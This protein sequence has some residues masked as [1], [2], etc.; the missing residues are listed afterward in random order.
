MS[1]IDP[2]RVGSLPTNRY[3]LEIDVP[4]EATARRPIMSVDYLLNQNARTGLDH[5]RR[6]R[7][8][9]YVL[10]AHLKRFDAMWDAFEAR[11]LREQILICQA[12]LE[13]E[14]Q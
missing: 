8:R 3:L 1:V 14:S 13:G 5:S 6:E 11:C 10:K 7:V 2:R 12:K 9:P 4:E